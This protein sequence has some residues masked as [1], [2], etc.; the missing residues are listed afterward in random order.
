MSSR[1]S[2]KWRPPYPLT[3]PLSGADLARPRLVCR[4]AKTRLLRSLWPLRIIKCVL[5]LVRFVIFL[6][7]TPYTCGYSMRE[8]SRIWLA[9]MARAPP[10]GRDTH[11]VLPSF[12]VEVVG[13]LGTSTVRVLVRFLCTMSALRRYSR[14]GRMTW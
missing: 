4:V 2:E 13:V 11:F 6:I 1:R 9:L 10:L 8:S 12:F 5:F 7:A 14:G 3:Y